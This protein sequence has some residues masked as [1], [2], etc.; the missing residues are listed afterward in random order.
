MP[1]RNIYLLKDIARLTGYSKA[2][3]KYYIKV[4]LIREVA[5]SPE[6]QFRYFND[7]TIA[8]LEKIRELRRNNKSINQIKN[9][10]L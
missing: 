8:T 5:R 1:Q 4:G 9:E 2:T 3:L 7:S 6:T 10:L